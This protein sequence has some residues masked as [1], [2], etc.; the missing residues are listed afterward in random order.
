MRI[1]EHELPQFRSATPEPKW[2]PPLL[3]VARRLLR[4]ALFAEAK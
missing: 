1:A 4:D 3:F 2:V